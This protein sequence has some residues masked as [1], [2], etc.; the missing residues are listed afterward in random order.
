M[1]K[2]SASLPRHT[3]AGLLIVATTLAVFAQCA[4]DEFIATDDQQYLRLNKNIPGELSIAEFRYAL[5]DMSIANW[6][7]IT[8][9]S[10]VLMAG[11]FGKDSASPHH[12]ANIVLHVANALLLYAVLF[13]MTGAAWP[14]LVA[15]LLFAVHPLRAESVAWVSERKGLLCAF[16][17]LLALLAYERYARKPSIAKYML[18][19][20]GFV[21]GLLSKAALL[22]LP[23]A[24]L[25]LDVWPLGRLRE[26]AGPR[27]RRMA[28]LVAEKLPMIALAIAMAALTWN[29]QTAAGAVQSLEN[30]PWPVRIANAVIAYAMYLANTLVPYH[31][32]FSYPHKMSTIFEGPQLIISSIV[33]VL[34]SIAAILMARSRPY[35]IVGWL[36]FLGMLIPVIGLI[37]LAGQ[38]RADRYTYLPQIGLLIALAWGLDELRRRRP[39]LKQQV[40]AA[41]TVWIAVIA[42]AG[43]IQTSHWQDNFSLF[44]HTVARAPNSPQAHYG[45]G[46]A[47]LM[48]DDLQAAEREFQIAVDLGVTEFQAYS[49][50][51]AIKLRKGELVHA[52]DLFAIALSLEP[53]NPDLM[54]NLG[55]ALFNMQQ[56]AEA[57]PL[58]QAAL[59]HDPGHLRAIELRDACLSALAPQ[60][61]SR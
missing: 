46:A 24:L 3:A 35:F 29:T 32:S 23:F 1:P 57:L 2:A 39:A 12:V 28:I 60:Q 37:Q 9:L 56:P 14:S 4:N 54:V 38:A 61:S 51:A 18:V 21:L 33:V 25:L 44:S 59:S 15:T 6:H 27:S 22:P 48:R 58:A 16:F 34:V 36:W 45:L 49:N 13:R 30:F 43:Y 47:Y 20:T 52:R 26:P 41:A 31:L 7:P 42:G 50:L 10:H 19:F 53:D 8:M 55:V 40:T 17:G 5:T 11:L